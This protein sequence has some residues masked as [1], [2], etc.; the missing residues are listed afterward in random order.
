MKELGETL[1]EVKGTYLVSVGGDAL[2]PV[3]GAALTFAVAR[4]H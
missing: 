4:W 1:K 3:W 2:G